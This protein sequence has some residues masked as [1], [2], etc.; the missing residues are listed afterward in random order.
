MVTNPIVNY[1]FRILLRSNWSCVNKIIEKKSERSGLVLS[2]KVSLLMKKY[3]CTESWNNEQSYSYQIVSMGLLFM[4]PS[5]T[6]F[7]Y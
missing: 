3:E 6:T 1:N 2:V 7:W 4:R 5:A